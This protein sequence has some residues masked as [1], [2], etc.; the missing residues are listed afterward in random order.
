MSQFTWN[1]DEFLRDL[2]EGIQD[3]LEVV[4]I[5]MQNEL[6]DVVSRKA[7]NKSNGGQPSQPGEPPARDTGVLA[8]SMTYNVGKGFVNFGVSRNSPA[9]QY[10]LP[11]EFGTTRMEA[12][13]FLRPTLQRMRNRINDLFL[14]GV[15]SNPKV[16]R[17]LD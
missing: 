1:G 7:S 6:E 12:R 3:G 10:A 2:E 15:K 9:N 14:R 16:K 4:G 8:R 11:L 13:P 5:T 17:W